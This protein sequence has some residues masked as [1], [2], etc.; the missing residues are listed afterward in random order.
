[1]CGLILLSYFQPKSETRI[2]VTF[3]VKECSILRSLLKPL[4]VWDKLKR[5]SDHSR[6]R[7]MRSRKTS[8]KLQHKFSLHVA[9]GYTCSNA[10]EG[11]VHKLKSNRKIDSGGE[12]NEIY[13]HFK[14]IKNLNFSRNW[15][16]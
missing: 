10:A 15:L 3:S 8:P 11:K 6:G 16:T 1:M 2:H 14:R 9:V 12:I 4:P 7:I 13:L 5:K